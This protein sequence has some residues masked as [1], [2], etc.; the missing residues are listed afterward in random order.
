MFV[1]N[2]LIL[3]PNAAQLNQMVTMLKQHFALKNL[4]KVQNY[5]KIQIQKTPTKGYL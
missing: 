4:G 3:A 5:L 1:N 2:V